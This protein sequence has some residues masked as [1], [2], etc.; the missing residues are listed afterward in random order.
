MSKVEGAINFLLP[1]FSCFYSEKCRKKI[2]VSM[3]L[4]QVFCVFFYKRKYF[5]FIFQQSGFTKIA[6]F[7]RNFI[8]IIWLLQRLGC[9]VAPGFQNVT[10]SKAD[11]IDLTNDAEVFQSS[12]SSHNSRYNN[13]NTKIQQVGRSNSVF[14][15]IT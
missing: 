11:V 8:F 15:V 7:G 2:F 10:K 1:I 6:S 12:S 14:L 5:G 4:I 3:L 9:S 13:I